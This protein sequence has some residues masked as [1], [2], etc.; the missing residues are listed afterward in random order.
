MKQDGKYEHLAQ[1]LDQC[2]SDAQRRLLV[3]HLDVTESQNP[4]E[5]AVAP[6]VPQLLP[7]KYGL[8]AEQEW[9][10]S[11]RSADHRLFESSRS[12][13]EKVNICTAVLHRQEPRPISLPRPPAGARLQL[14]FR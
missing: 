13:R 4:E 7:R 14:S 8:R 1:W 12:L 5:P 11:E 10:V 6:D 9:A 2:P 3:A